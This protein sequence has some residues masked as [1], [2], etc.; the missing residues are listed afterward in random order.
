MKRRYESLFTPE[1]ESD[2]L[3]LY[4][5]IAEHSSPE[6]ALS[7]IE[8]V[9]RWTNSLQTFPERGTAR[10]DIRPGLRLISFDRRVSIAF[11][12]RT[13]SVIILRIL[14]AGR[15]ISTELAGAE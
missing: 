14:Y 5:Y 6:R 3:E 15:D 2:L 13:D 7:Y 8:R 4:D 10:D 11:Q 9:E 1:A 12:V